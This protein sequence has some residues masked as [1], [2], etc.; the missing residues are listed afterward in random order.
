M[1]PRLF[2][3]VQTFSVGQMS[4]L[5]DHCPIRAV[6]SVNIFT[7]NDKENNEYIE[8]PKKLPWNTDIA[9]RFGKI[10]QTTEYKLKVENSLLSLNVGSQ[11]EVDAITQNLTNVLVEMQN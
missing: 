4:T 10:L 8:S 3:S 11:E 2:D 1:S 7:D 6:L 5:S 9:L